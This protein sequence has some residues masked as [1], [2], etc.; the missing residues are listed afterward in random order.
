M[1][2]IANF[3]HHER[4]RRL[5]GRTIEELTFGIKYSSYIYCVVHREDNGGGEDVESS[6]RKSWALFFLLREVVD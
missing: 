2:S 4:V 6:Q 3:N 1:E 5:R